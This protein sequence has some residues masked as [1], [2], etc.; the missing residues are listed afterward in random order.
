MK[1]YYDTIHHAI[2]ILDNV[3]RVDVRFDNMGYWLVFTYTD[4]TVMKTELFTEEGAKKA[5]ED[6]RE[7]LTA[8]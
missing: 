1:V 7:A 4:G 3:R 5:I 6:V 8:S 2:F